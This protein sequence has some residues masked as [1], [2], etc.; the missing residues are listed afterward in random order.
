MCL[1]AGSLAFGKSRRAEEKEKQRHLGNDLKPGQLAHWQAVFPRLFTL[2]LSP[3]FF[4]FFLVF[5]FF[6]FSYWRV[7]S[8]LS[9]PRSPLLRPLRSVWFVSKSPR[10]IILS[11]QECRLLRT[12][13]WHLVKCRAAPQMFVLI[14]SL[15]GVSSASTVAGLMRRWGVITGFPFTVPAVIRLLPIPYFARRLFAAYFG[16]HVFLKIATHMPIF[17]Q[18][19]C[20]L[21]GYYMKTPTFLTNVLFRNR[22]V[23]LKTAD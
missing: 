16:M 6:F 15:F 22:L 4:V 3:P 20:D 9:R 11:H 21:T 7:S 13:H 12:A 8:S 5:L 10:A 19:C 2:C 18:G 23:N 17:A 1:W 14:D